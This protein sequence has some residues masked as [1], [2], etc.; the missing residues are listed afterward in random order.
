MLNCLLGWWPFPTMDIYIY[1]YMW[2]K[3][4]CITTKSTKLFRRK[5]HHPSH[6]LRLTG[7]ATP[8]RCLLDLSMGKK[9]QETHSKKW[10][11]VSKLCQ[12]HTELVNNW[13]QQF[14]ALNNTHIGVA[15]LP[16]QCHETRL[17]L[18]LYWVISGTFVDKSS[19]YD[20]YELT[21]PVHVRNMGDWLFK[22]ESDHKYK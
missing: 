7:F 20:L 14:G 16:V 13:M 18:R 10:R 21:W 15:N 2:Y 5:T 9:P 1:I 17:I 8:Q 12:T 6:T 4:V 3:H 22:I 19:M 11:T